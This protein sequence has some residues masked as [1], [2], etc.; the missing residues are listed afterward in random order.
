MEA[1]EHNGSPA[2][3]LAAA[4]TA[5]AQGAQRLCSLTA[6]VWRDPSGQA[7]WICLFWS[8]WFSLATFPM[9]YGLREVT[10]LVCLVFLLLYYRRAWRQSVLCRL[11]VRPLFYCLGGMILIGVFFSEDVWTSLL[12]AGTGI[13]K[14]FILPFI[15][16]ECVR[17]EK[18]LRRLVWA[19]VLACF[20]QGL[21]GLWQ[22]CTGYDFIMG[23]QP[24][25]GRL[26]G[27]LGDY[28]VGNYIA[29]ALVPACALWFLLRR[30]LPPAAAVFL[31]AASLWPAFFL[32]VGAASRSGALALAALGAGFGL[33]QW[34]YTRRLLARLDRNF[35]PAEQKSLLYTAQCYYACEKSVTR[36]AAQL[37]VHKN[38]LLYRLHKLWSTL[39]VDDSGEFQQEFTVR[40]ILEYYLGKQGPR[41]LK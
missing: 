25:A 19:C 5:L 35:S 16:M 15:A 38:T 20:W 11:P 39:G 22:A 27:S 2:G 26:T 10:P 3:R 37:Y 40:L 32:L 13:N 28:T 14:G 30:A 29:L 8:F 7:P 33:V 12:H 23:Y 31:W 1:T 9:G 21:D 6:S 18:D 24:N 4:R 36:A 41:A 34:L 17:D